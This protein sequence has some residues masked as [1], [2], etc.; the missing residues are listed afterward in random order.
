MAPRRLRMLII[1]QN[2]PQA[3]REWAGEFI[4]RQARY[5]EAEGFDSEFI[6]PRPW[7]PWPL[8]LL[9]RWR[10]YGPENPLLAQPGLEA[11]WVGYIR[12]PSARFITTEGRFM[13]RSVLRLA[14]RM[15]RARPFDLVW[16]AQMNGEAPT[17]IRVG[18]AL[19]LPVAVM[20]IGTDIMVLPDRVPALRAIHARVLEQ[21]DLAIAVS[22]EIARRMKTFATLKRPP[23]VARLARDPSA[24]RPA[25]DRAA[26]RAAH[27]I[28]PED[29][30]AVFV[31]RVE[32]AKGMEDLLS[33]LPS[34]LRR[35]PRLRFALL[36]DGALRGA[37]V[38]AGDAVRPGAVLAPGRVDP[39]EVPG[40]LQSSDFMVFPSHS[41]GLPQ[42]VLEA[43]NCGL[44]VIATDVGG[45]AEAVLE[46]RTGLLVPSRDPARLEAAIDAL[47][48]DE[49][50]RA[51]MGEAGLAHALA[52]FDPL[53]HTKR[54]ADALRSIVEAEG[55]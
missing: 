50:T 45:T 5:L 3:Q 17:A 53:V 36:G 46:G 37:L 13:G 32:T 25:S 24:F 52:E 7:A 10:Q 1:S 55:R 28:E 12:P 16:A 21:T 8:H 26:V 42:A 4:V 31:G 47:V 6:V 38:A 48:T 11:N 54:L 40:W 14:R 39:G 19:G 29:R 2:Y 43:M 34:V 15:H 9:P 49:A 41:E 35:H 23:F 20:S 44:A 22:P 51:Q 27:G 30:L 18:E 33:I